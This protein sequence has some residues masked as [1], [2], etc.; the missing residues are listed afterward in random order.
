MF[1]FLIGLIREVIKTKS[2]GIVKKAFAQIDY[3]TIILLTGL[4][5]VI[6]GITRAGVIDWLGTTISKAGGSSGS[7]FIV[8]R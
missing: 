5:V 4:F 7:A 6:G 2:F 3:Y 8:L 1:F